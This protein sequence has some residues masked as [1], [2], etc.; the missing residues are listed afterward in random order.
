MTNHTNT[1]LYTGV[2][3]N[4][5]KRVAEHRAGRGSKFTAKYKVTKLVWYERFSRVGDAI[6]AE[7]TI[8]AGS[9]AK[10]LRLI[11]AVNPHWN[12]LSG[13]HLH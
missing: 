5:N 8:K 13:S 11:E 1:V 2:T 6:P 3:N 9:R 10:K 12:D 7:K 4:L